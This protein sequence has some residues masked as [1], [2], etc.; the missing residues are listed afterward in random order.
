[1]KKYINSTGN[2]FLGKHYYG[3]S[4]TN[5]G[6][7]KIKLSNKELDEVL[8]RIDEGYTV[9]FD[10]QLTLQ[11]YQSIIKQLKERGQNKSVFNR[12]KIK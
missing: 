6:R 9:R 12:E 11:Q 4:V 1:M 3:S 10:N 8:S 7:R 5:Y 2:G